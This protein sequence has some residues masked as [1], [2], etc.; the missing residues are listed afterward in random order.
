M[1]FSGGA[2]GKNLHAS[3][4]DVR[5]AG[6]IS[7]ISW[8]SRKISWRREWQPTPVY[9]CLRNPMNRGAWQATVHSIVKS[10]M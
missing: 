3:A 2:S 5:D 7:G 4:G 9:S 6:S 1:G 8:I 10:R